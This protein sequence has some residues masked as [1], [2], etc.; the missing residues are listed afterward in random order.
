MVSWTAQLGKILGS[1][2]GLIALIMAGEAVA[3][4]V[5]VAPNRI[6]LDGRARSATVFLSNRG[7]HAETYRISLAFFKMTETGALVRADSLLS[8]E[9]HHAEQVLRY[10]PRR[11]VVPAGGSQTVRLLLRRP[12]DL[13]VEGKEFRA[14]LSVASVPMVPRLREVEDGPLPELGADQFSVR[15]VASVETLIPIIVRFGNPEA[16]LTITGAELLNDAT[17]GQPLVTFDLERRG[18][19]SVYGDLTLVHVDGSGRQSQVYYARGIAI[20]PPNDRRIF[21]IR[22]DFGSLDPRSGSLLIDYRET[23]AGG[24]DLEV[25]ARIDSPRLT[26]R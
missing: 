26:R 2:C 23:A 5:S 9:D 13:E 7:Q 17:D 18:E 10:S 15:P 8:A 24:G 6:L 22:P 12:H 3:Q 1:F 16:E 11:V 19:R 20:Y 14:H 4:G 25:Q 21:E